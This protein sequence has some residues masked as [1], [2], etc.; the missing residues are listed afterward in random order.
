SATK[1]STLG[2]GLTSFLIVGRTSPRAQL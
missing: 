1:V 2:R